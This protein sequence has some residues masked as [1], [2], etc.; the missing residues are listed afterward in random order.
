MSFMNVSL[1]SV[2]GEVVANL[3]SPRKTTVNPD[4]FTRTFET[5]LLLVFQML[6][7]CSFLH[8]MK[9]SLFNSLQHH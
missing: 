3:C 2:S 6:S 7:C 1:I 9:Q 5:M 4:N 8:S